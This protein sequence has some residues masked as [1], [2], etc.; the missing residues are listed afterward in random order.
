MLGR[1]RP[2]RYQVLAAINAVHTDA[3]AFAGTDWA[4]VAALY[5]QLLVLEPTD[6]VRLNRAIAI[7]ELD[8]PEVA[9]ADVDRLDLGDYHPWHATRADL[10]RRVGRLDEARTA[11]DAA[12]GATGNP[13]ERAHLSRRRDRLT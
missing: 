8:G 2:G 9:L 3:S 1:R 7:A 12:I 13:L 11:Y 10:L 4:Q 5:D 6:I